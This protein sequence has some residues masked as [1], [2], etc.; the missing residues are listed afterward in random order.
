MTIYSELQQNVT[1]FRNA[2]DNYWEDLAKKISPFLGDMLVYYGVAGKTLRF[3][4]DRETPVIVFGQFE[5]DKFVQAIPYNLEK[6]EEELQLKFAVRVYLS[7]AG[8]EMVDTGL[9][10]K[11]ALGKKE[12]GYYVEFPNGAL[13][14]A[15]SNGKLDFTDAYDYILQRLYQYTDR[16]KF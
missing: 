8:S 3:Q 5:N 16:S 9:T 12:G 11:C 15:E 2:Q 4:D 14:C 10:F 13:P 6:D 7:K 1:E